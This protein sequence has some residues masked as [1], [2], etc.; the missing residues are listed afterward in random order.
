MKI[1]ALDDYQDAFR[2][3][4]CFPRLAGHDVAVFHDTVKDPEAL[5]ERLADADAVLLMQQRTPLARAVIERLPRL[6]LVSQ[7][8]RNVAHIDI[9]A[10]TERGIVVSAGGAGAPN[11]TAELAWGLILAAL[12]QIPQEAERLKAGL[13]LGSLGRGVAGKTL[14]V[15][16]FGR[17]GSLVAEVGRAFGMRVAC[18]GRAGSTARARG[19]VRRGGEPRKRFSPRRTC[20]ASTSR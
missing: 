19:R 17:I 3:L 18:W 16:A 11:A 1:V 20:S 8:G 15:Y 6:R 12:R 2:T 7:T 10:C 9:P 13:W 14:G 4:S 5:A